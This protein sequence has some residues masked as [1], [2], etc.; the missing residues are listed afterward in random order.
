MVEWLVVFLATVSSGDEFSFIFRDMSLVTLS[1]GHD[2]DLTTLVDL[3]LLEI[4]PFTTVQSEWPNV[5]Y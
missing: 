3:P 5:K 2:I 1:T 4:V